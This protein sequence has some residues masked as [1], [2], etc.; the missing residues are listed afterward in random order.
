MAWF[1]DA[2]AGRRITL[3]E[4]THM[5]SVKPVAV[6]GWSR[7]RARMIGVI[8]TVCLS[9]AG[10]P[11]AASACS[12][13]GFSISW[14]AGR[15]DLVVVGTMASVQAE[16]LQVA[17]QQQ[18]VAP[19]RG[20]FRVEEILKGDPPADP[21]ELVLE[22]GAEYSSC[23]HEYHGYLDL[24]RAVLMLPGAQADGT[25]LAPWWPGYLPLPDTD[26]RS[27]GLY[28]WVEHAASRLE[29]PASV[30]VDGN[31]KQEVGQPL[32]ATV[33]ITNRLDVELPCALAGR[34]TT[35]SDDVELMITMDVE[36][37][38]SRQGAEGE[39][40]SVEVAPGSTVS[41][42][43]A[44]HFDIVEPGV[45]TVSGYLRLSA[46]DSRH[47]GWSFTSYTGPVEGGAET[48]GMSVRLWG[49][50][51]MPPSAVP[52]ESWGTVKSERR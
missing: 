17:D 31:P 7:A 20:T 32:Q 14:L 13:T 46:G 15:A 1:E 5:Q 52:R 3:Q 11:T 10:L 38:V 35:H 21:I 45:Y 19:R 43:L 41:L 28:R 44:D 33:S 9:V 26:H 29:S 37:A 2:E 40:L 18:Q 12:P 50:E 24:Q 51:A 27:T 36:G 16:T 4:E 39:P 49:Y 34:G 25:Y 8:G 23:T 47:R 6:K 42:E 22:R 48:P 30:A